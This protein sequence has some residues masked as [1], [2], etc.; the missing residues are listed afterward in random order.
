MSDVMTIFDRD[1]VRRRRER[2]ATR[3]H[4]YDFLFR[5]VGERLADRLDDVTRTFPRALDLGCHTGV[6]AEALAGRGGIRELVQCDLSLA[7]T[8]RAVAMTQR[9]EGERP[10]GLASVA[11]VADEEW[12]PFAPGSFDL[13]VSNL[14]LHWV[15][16]LP[17][18]LVQARNALKPDGLFIATL[19]G[20]GTLSELRTAL[21]DA[22][23][24][25][26]GGWSPRVSPFPVTGDLGHLLQRAGFA[27]PV[28]DADRITV[29]YPDT[30]RLM[31]DLRGMGETNAV[32][33]R[34]RVPTRRATLAAA[35]ARYAERFAGTDGRLPATFEIL[36]LTA[37]SPHESQPK[38]AKP[39][40]AG[41]SLA[42]ALSSQGC[43]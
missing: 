28:V 8:R 12:L 43:P 13:I 38:P 7:M 5:E 11:V 39:G 22:E 19:F 24:A 1:L 40:S 16:D 10:P 32:L 6:L 29:S 23:D 2:A 4:E 9:A 21:M 17:G 35:A 31:T 41:M 14:S 26:E 20:G 18:A 34:R 27:L 36:T 37:W 42:E 25:E 15:N 3:F 30:I 33:E